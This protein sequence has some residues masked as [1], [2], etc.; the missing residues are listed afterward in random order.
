MLGCSVGH[1]NRQVL[2]VH[3]GDLT[4]DQEGG[5]DQLAERP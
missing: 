3:R 4:S 2:R 1:L 5:E